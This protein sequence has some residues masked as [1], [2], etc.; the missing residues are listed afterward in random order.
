MKY[1][2]LATVMLAAANAWS[3]TVTAA[4]HCYQAR[5]VAYKNFLD[6]NF[7]GTPNNLNPL[8]H[9]YASTIL[10]NETYTLKEM[11]SEPNKDQFIDTMFEE[12]ESKFKEGIWE[13][14]PKT[15]MLNHYRKKR[16]EG[17]DIKRHQIMM[18]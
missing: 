13:A 5:V 8:A 16:D 1:G 2:L 17:F 6:R 14:V 7:D 4:A 3:T 18:I 9:I 15:I 11:L 12:V 10:N